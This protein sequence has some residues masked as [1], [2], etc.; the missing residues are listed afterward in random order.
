M[1]RR[2]RGKSGT[3]EQGVKMLLKKNFP[4]RLNKNKIPKVIHQQ[5]MKA[6]NVHRA[7]RR[8]YYKK[9]QHVKTVSR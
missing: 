2:M 3:F 5:R 8:A 4:L 9:Q 6:Q 1:D 7:A